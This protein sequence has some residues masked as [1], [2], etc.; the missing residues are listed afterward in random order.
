MRDAH[1]A[2]QGDG[3]GSARW[4]VRGPGNGGRRPVGEPRI[5]ATARDGV[6]LAGV[7][8][9]KGA[10]ES[11]LASSLYSSAETY[12]SPGFGDFVPTGP[13]SRAVT[14]LS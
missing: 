3:G 10:G 13:P 7:G 1:R 14:K 4:F 2:T 8:G 6:A 5:V 9:L 12:T 11:L